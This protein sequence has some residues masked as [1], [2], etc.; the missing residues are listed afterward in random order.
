MRPIG[1]ADLT[2]E[3]RDALVEGF[4][5]LLDPDAGEVFSE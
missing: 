5:R 1:P 2:P 4:D 3:Q